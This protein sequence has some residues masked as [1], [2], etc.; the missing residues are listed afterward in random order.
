M[1]NKIIEYSDL[2]SKILEIKKKE[3][4]SAMSWSL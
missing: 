1:N 2:E 4:N 3:K